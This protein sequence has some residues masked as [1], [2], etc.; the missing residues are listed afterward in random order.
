MHF[1]P[2]RHYYA[3]Q[4]AHSLLGQALKAAL[5]ALHPTSDG[6]PPQAPPPQVIIVPAATIQATPGAL[7][8]PAPAGS[9]IVVQQP[10]AEK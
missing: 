6:A 8:S 1:D 5:D 3:V 9:V 10:P 7:A 2:R 4:R